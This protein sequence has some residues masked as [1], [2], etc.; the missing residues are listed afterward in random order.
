MIID[1]QN[2]NID[3]L[4]SDKYMHKQLKNGIFLSDNQMSILNMYK[5][6][7]EECSDVKELIFLIEEELDNEYDE[8]LDMICREISEFNY[9]SNTN[10]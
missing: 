4:I 10:K 3:D 5:I 2:I 9:Y 7:F 6:N 1:N 8:D